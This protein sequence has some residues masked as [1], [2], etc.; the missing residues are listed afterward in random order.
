MGHKLFP[1]FWNHSRMMFSLLLLSLRGYSKA[2]VV[3]CLSPSLGVGSPFRMDHDSFSLKRFV[4]SDGVFNQF[5]AQFQCDKRT[6]IKGSWSVLY[7]K[8]VIEL[9]QSS[10][11]W[12]LLM[13]PYEPILLGAN[14][15]DFRSGS[16]S[17]CRRK[18]RNNSLSWWTFGQFR[19]EIYSTLISP[20]WNATVDSKCLF[21]QGMLR[22][23]VVTPRKVGG[24]GNLQ[25]S[26]GVKLGKSCLR[27]VNFPFQDSG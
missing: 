12:W 21:L 17:S 25:R 6:Y 22:V 23:T 26:A 3:T 15:L 4:A 11:W 16:L 5:D 18:S 8:L 7:S 1:C 13:K 2:F 9:V 27:W 20:L 19:W 10:H 24:T 14:T